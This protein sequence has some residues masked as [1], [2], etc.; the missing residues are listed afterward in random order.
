MHGRNKYQSRE[1]RQ[2]VRDILMREWD[3]IGVSGL[4]GYEDEYDAYVSTVYVKLMDDGA[5]TYQLAYSD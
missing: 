1:N 5:T 3:P 2:I 4:D